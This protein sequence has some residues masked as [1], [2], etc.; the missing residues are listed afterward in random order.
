[1]DAKSF[2]ALMS[3][4]L[5]TGDLNEEIV[6]DLFLEQLQAKLKEGQTLEVKNVGFFKL[7]DAQTVLFVNEQGGEDQ[8]FEKIHI[9]GKAENSFDF[10]EESFSVGGNASFVTAE[11]VTDEEKVEKLK[12]FSNALSEKLDSFSVLNDFDPLS[13]F[14]KNEDELSSDDFEQEL[15]KEIEE[16]LLTE[17]LENN[18]AEELKEDDLP[19][20]E[21]SKPN[22]ETEDSLAEDLAEEL[23]DADN[24]EN[25]PEQT[26]DEEQATEEKIETEENQDD[27][28]KPESLENDVL[29][30]K[31]LENA[32]GDIEESDIPDVEETDKT[33]PT[34]EEEKPKKKKF[35][36]FGKKKEKEPK[37]EKKKDK[38]NESEESEGKEKSE[39]KK[40]LSKKLLIILISVF[41]LLTL[42]GVY[43]FFFMGSEEEVPP[44][45][46]RKAEIEDS[47]KKAR[48]PITKKELGEKEETTPEIDVD[49]H[50]PKKEEEE[51]VSLIDPRLI[52]EFP[53]EKRIT[54]T[55][56]FANGK[57]M[58]QL[59]SWRDSQK[60]SHIAQKL[61][62][63]GFNAF[64]VK[65]NLPQLGGMWYRV[66]VGFF[67]TL[68][69]AKDFLRKREYL[70]VR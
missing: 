3:E 30:E 53:N 32:F 22:Q 58:V 2:N 19:N 57:Y 49:I 55:I 61:Y 48:T 29:D 6:Y 28:E 66:R 60:A 18:L 43:F 33:T 15:H 9:S 70:Y 59:S 5:D 68:K 45:D 8:L 25:E 11:E 1:M 27:K 35:K 40:G 64:I 42:G 7:E 17:E 65:A 24:E 14:S 47:I 38:K 12:T 41:V 13:Y 31:D 20:E 39:E 50:N 69:E 36:L 63:N 52:K 4:V 56:Y 10:N 21:E 46:H 34:E 44:V 62:V 51:G 67:D 23:A 37:K 16:N 26:S 54:N